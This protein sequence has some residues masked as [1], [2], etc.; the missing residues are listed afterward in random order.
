MSA[1]NEN[2]HRRSSYILFIV[3]FSLNVA[4]NIGITAYFVYSHWYLKEDILRVKFN[5]RTQPTI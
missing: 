5:T 1:K 2:K 4:I 3:L